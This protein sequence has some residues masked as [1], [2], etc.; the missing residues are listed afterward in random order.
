MRTLP[1]FLALILASP[2][3]PAHEPIA[4]AAPA[5]ELVPAAAA[6]A[7]GVVDAFSDALKAGRLDEVKALLDPAVQVFEGG[8]VEADR[9]AYFAEHAA[10]DAKFLA[11]AEVTREARTA[12][13]HGDLAW[14]GT[15]SIVAR[16]GKRHASIE[17]MVLR[18]GKDGW[19]IVHIHWSS[20]ALPAD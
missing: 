2:M 17:T 8:H 1:F 11:S 13:A 16:D 9:D 10:A 7:V 20:R 18:R 4:T 15:R 6:E 12:D 3:L 14:V 19:K 5:T